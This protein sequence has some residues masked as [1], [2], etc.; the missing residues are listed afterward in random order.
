[1]FFVLVVAQLA[2]PVA[3]AAQS[4]IAEP[5][6]RS[7]QTSAQFHRPNSSLSRSPETAAK[8]PRP[9]CACHDGNSK[10][11]RPRPEAFASSPPANLAAPVSRPRNRR[12]DLQLI[13]LFS[14]PIRLALFEES[15]NSLPCIMAL[16]QHRQVY[17]FRFFEL[18]HE[19]RR[20]EMP[21]CLA[22]QTYNARTQLT[23]FSE[24]VVQCCWQPRIRNHA[25]D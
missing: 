7:R 18:L 2:A 23:K 11:L 17:A 10:S 13:H 16:H 25:C 21:Q 14:L 15:E 12:R 20:M 4:S 22:R 24:Q 5:S 3:V 1:M 9:N 19:I 8:P 6:D